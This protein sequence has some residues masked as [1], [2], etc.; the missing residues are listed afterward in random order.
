MK[1][2]EVTITGGKSNWIV[3]ISRINCLIKQVI[4]GKMKRLK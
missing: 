2:E 3:H 4:E 1:N